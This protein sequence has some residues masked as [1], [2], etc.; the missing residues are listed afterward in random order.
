MKRREFITLLGSA[1][2]WPLIARAQSSAKLSTVGILGSSSRSVASQWVSAFVKRLGELGWNDGRNVAIE[3]RWS[4]GGTERSVQVIS[5][6]VRR[7]V[8]V[9]VTTGSANVIAAK[10]ATSLIPIVFAGV[11]DPIGTGLIES[12]ARP[13]GNATGLS[14]QQPNLAGKRLGLLR[15]LVPTLD[16]LAIMGNVNAPS[17]VMEMRE[18]QEA[19][20]ALALDVDVL[21]IRRS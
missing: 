7:N 17:V 1:A 14:L 4:E 5:E 3:V 2:A 6:F 13:G 15:E 11:G 8:D 21:E 20:Q 18:A 9:I 16:R 12:L 10:Q 19:A